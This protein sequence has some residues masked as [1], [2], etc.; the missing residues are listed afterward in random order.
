[1]TAF[2]LRISKILGGIA[3]ALLTATAWS[4]LGGCVYALVLA[5][6]G[7]DS[8]ADAWGLLLYVGSISAAVAAGV[9]LVTIVV[10]GVPLYRWTTRRS[11]T[12]IGTYGWAGLGVSLIVAAIFALAHVIGSWLLVRD[13]WFAL[14]LILTGGPI[15]ALTFWLA[16]RPDRR[17]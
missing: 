16:T 13:L 14:V 17:A 10:I 11:R 8:S 2:T 5:G 6:G 15:V 1:M 9:A 12:S 7:N 4:F 3:L